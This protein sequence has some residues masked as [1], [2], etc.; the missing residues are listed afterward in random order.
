MK[1]LD[2][3]RD[4][5]N[6]SGREDRFSSEVGGGEERVIRSCISWVSHSTSSPSS[7]DTSSTVAILGPGD[8]KSGIDLGNKTDSL[9]EFGAV[10]ESDGGIYSSSEVL[11]VSGGWPKVSS[12]EDE[13][14][15]LE[16]DEAGECVRLRKR[17]GMTLVAGVRVNETADSFSRGGQGKSKD[18]PARLSLIS[19]DAEH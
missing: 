15:T 3:R 11:G 6:D 14:A 1:E 19:T 8:R 5:K 12:L 2:V 10:T 13:E 9:F 16:M 18:L 4:G 7:S 17:M